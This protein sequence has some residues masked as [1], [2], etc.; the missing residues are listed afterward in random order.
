MKRW[1]YRIETDRSKLNE[2]G[3][4]GW[5]LINVILKEQ[6]EVFYLKRAE[7]SLKERITLEQ[8]DRVLEGTDK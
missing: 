8:R 5:E 1:E 6:Q 4:E 2:W 3:Q 7:M